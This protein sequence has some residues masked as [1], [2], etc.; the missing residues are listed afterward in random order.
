[1]W[2]NKNYNILINLIITC[3]REFLSFET[4]A[5]VIATSV[6]LL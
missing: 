3:V 4:I 2:L 5:I 1:M 6:A